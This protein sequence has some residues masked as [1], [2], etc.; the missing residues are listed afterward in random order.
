MNECH[1]VLLWMCVLPVPQVRIQDSEGLQKRTRSQNRSCTAR[2][3]LK[4]SKVKVRKKSHVNIMG[5]HC[6]AG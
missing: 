3:I 2:D 6:D 4:L 1:N 5:L